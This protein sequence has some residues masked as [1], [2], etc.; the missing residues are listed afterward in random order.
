M[1]AAV[2]Q[3]EQLYDEQQQ[4]QESQVDSKSSTTPQQQQMMEQIG[5]DY[6]AASTNSLLSSV[7]GVPA[8]FSS[9]PRILPQNLNQFAPIEAAVVNQYL[10]LVYE[11][12]NTMEEERTSQ[13]AAS[14]STK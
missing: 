13:S 3:P 2:P 8:S 11:V 12:L 6:M 10:P 4:T 7:Y 14:E 9:R 5:V 1:A